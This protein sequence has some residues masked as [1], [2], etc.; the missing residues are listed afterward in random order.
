MS[1]RE[2]GTL[3]VAHSSNSANVDRLTGCASPRNEFAFLDDRGDVPSA[4][5]L[6]CG[7]TFWTLRPRNVQMLQSFFLESFSHPR[8]AAHFGLR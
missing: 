5:A 7:V 4:F 6:A 1:H 8:G 3:E 2:L